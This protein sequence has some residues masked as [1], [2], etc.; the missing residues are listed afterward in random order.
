M[1]IGLEP[2]R[3]RRLWNGRVFASKRKENLRQRVCIDPWA[4]TNSIG[5]DD[6]NNLFNVQQHWHRHV[7]MMIHQF[8]LLVYRVP[9]RNFLQIKRDRIFL[10]K[11]GRNRR[12]FFL[13]RISD[14]IFKKR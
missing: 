3:R 2:G 13:R 6:E 7:D 1:P 4:R 11:K 10:Q 12:V 9:F 8:V 14:H 5:D